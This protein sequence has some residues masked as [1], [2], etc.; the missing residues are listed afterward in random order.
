MF[1]NTFKKEFSTLNISFPCFQLCPHGTPIGR[2]EKKVKL[3]GNYCL[4]FMLMS[5]TNIV[6]A[7]KTISYQ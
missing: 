4:T 5:L 6:Y 7:G 1:I 2:E 3:P